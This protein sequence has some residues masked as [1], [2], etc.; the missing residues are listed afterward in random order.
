MTARQTCKELLARYGIARIPFITLHTVERARALTLL[1]EVAEELSLPFCIHTLSKGVY[2][3]ATDKV[4]SDDKSVYGALDFIGEQMK[5]RANTTLVLTETPDLSTDTNDA[6]QLLDLVT[7]ANETGGQIIVL[8]TAPIWNRLQRL[9]LRLELPLPDEDEMEQIVRGYID[10]YRGEITIEW[11]DADIREAASILCGVTAIEAENVM[12]ALIAKKS[13]RREDMDEVRTAKDRLFSDISGLEKIT[14][15]ES[16]R[17]VGGLTGLRNWLDEKR[18]LFTAEKRS[19]LR[20]KGLKSPRGI[21]LVGVPGCGQIPLGKG[22]LRQLE[23][24]AL[25]PRLCDRA[26]QLRRADRAAAAERAPDSGERRAVHPLDRRD[27]KGAL[28][29]GQLERRRRLHAHGRAVPLLA[30]GVPQA[31]LCRRDGER[32]LHAPLGAPAARAIP[33]SSSSSTCRPPTSA[34]TSCTSTCESI[35]GSTSR[36]HSPTPSSQ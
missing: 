34:A 5:H 31:G 17:D 12:A 21:L 30:A 29:R 28:G 9:G 4:L 11:T 33:T 1:K 24:P 23:T 19:L 26:G 15:D 10:D 3:L 20:E 14:V 22:D 25:P 7:L 35:W 16:V 13:I 32:R 27:R 2:D 6:R 8:T 36:A 18:L